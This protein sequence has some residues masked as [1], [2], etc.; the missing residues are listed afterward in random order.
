MARDAQDARV[1]R[2]V[3]G[4]VRGVRVPSI[5]AGGHD[6]Q[7]PPS[8]SEVLAEGIPDAQLIVFEKSGHYPFT[9]EPKEFWAA[10]RNVFGAP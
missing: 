7:M 8:C 5:H 3:Q 2:P 10:V 4:A 6:P 1:A 9:E